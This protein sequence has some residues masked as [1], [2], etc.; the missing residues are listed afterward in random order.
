MVRWRRDQTHARGGDA[1]FRD[2]RVDLVRWQLATFPGLCA[3]GHL[4]L[5]VGAV[6]QVVAGHTEAARCDLLDGR[7]LPVAIGL[8][9]EAVWIFAALAG[10]GHR[11]Q[12]I[13]SD[14]QR[15]MCLRRDGAVAHRAGGETLDDAGDRFDL[16]NVDWLAVRGELEHAA[17]SCQLLGLLIDLV[18][19]VAEDRVLTS[20]GGV[21]Q[22][23]DGLRVEQVVLA[24]AAP[25]VLAAEI[26]LAV[27]LLF[28]TRQECAAV[29]SRNI[30]CDLIETDTFQRRNSSGEVLV[31]E[32]L[33]QTDGVGQL[34]AT[35]GLQ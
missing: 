8:H 12:A 34:S 22:C 32:L 26:Q 7:A 2:P 27:G 30:F 14:G 5:D 3:L 19:V 23:V 21:L 35:V 6:G 31:Q 20:A 29:T 33:R 24:F 13:H 17:Q 18:G 25:L 9:F 10:V 28:R 16:I 15:L 11:T 4:D 1:D